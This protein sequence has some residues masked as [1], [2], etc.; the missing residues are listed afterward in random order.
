MNPLRK[1]MH[2]NFKIGTMC[3]VANLLTQEENEWLAS[4]TCKLKVDEPKI[5]TFIAMLVRDAYQDD[6][7]SGEI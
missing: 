5:A 4:E 2:R 1:M 6:L 7:E 3:N